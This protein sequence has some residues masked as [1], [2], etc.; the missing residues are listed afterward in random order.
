[1][2]VFARKQYSKETEYYWVEPSLST[3]TFAQALPVKYKGQEP[4]NPERL[5]RFFKKHTLSHW[6]LPEALEIISDRSPEVMGQANMEQRED[7]RAADEKQKMIQ[8]MMKTLKKEKGLVD[9]GEM[10]NLKKAADTMGV[11][12]ETVKKK[13]EKGPTKP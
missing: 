13:K 9:V 7:D 4:V 2:G 6:S 3:T 11:K 8:K 12:D 10:M 1:M 5:L